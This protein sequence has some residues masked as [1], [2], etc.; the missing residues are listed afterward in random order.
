MLWIIWKGDGS[1][2]WSV[3]SRPANT[4][5]FYHHRSHHT[6]SVALSSVTDCSPVYP[7]VD[8][9]N[10]TTLVIRNL[11]AFWVMKSRV[12]TSWQGINKQSAEQCQRKWRHEGVSIAKSLLWQLVWQ[13]AVWRQESY[14]YQANEQW[15]CNTD[16]CECSKCELMSGIFLT[17]GFQLIRHCG[18]F[19]IPDGFAWMDWLQVNLIK[20]LNVRFSFMR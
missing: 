3:S 6:L 9:Q 8:W 12:L 10:E 19:H 11:N 18:L 7:R 1:V 5:Y 14:I 15:T 4:R 13:A 16:T 17:W 2:G 20:K